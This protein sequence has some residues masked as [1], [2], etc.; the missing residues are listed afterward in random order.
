[1][2][3]LRLILACFV[4][5][6][7]LSIGFHGYNLG[8]MAVVL[9]YLLA[10]LV[11]VRLWGRIR[12]QPSA[13]L[14]FARDRLLRIMP[15]YLAGIALSSVVWSYAPSSSF[16]HANPSVLDW[17]AN[18]TIIPLNFFMYTGLSSFM[19]IPPAWSL[20][21]ELQFYLIAPLLFSLGASRIGLVFLASF[22]VFT[23]AQFQV[24][25]TD[26]FGYRLLPGILFV[27]LLGSSFTERSALHPRT[28]TQ[29]L[30]F[31]MSWVLLG[32]YLLSLLLMGDHHLFR[33]EV[34][35]GLFCGVPLI[36]L[37]QQQ[38]ST[39]S[40]LKVVNRRA[41]ELSY[42]MF[43]YHFPVIWTLQLLGLPSVD[44]QALPMVLS[45][46]LLLAAIGHWFIERP[47]WHYMRPR[48]S[49]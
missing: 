23:L 31:F 1:M 42:G 7:H 9:F 48:F 37:L 12:T 21:A 47:L 5:M 35:A 30:I 19:L 25:D 4:M 18:L 17:L 32:V 29:R 33:V 49:A 20:A 46:S 22:S 43:L 44:T 34:A 39:K 24:L 3:V 10:G 36:A 38:P 41:G 45:F 26:Y 14:A 6:S 27:F 11:V 28:S 16:L 40:W 13:A 2:G 8:V 15:Q